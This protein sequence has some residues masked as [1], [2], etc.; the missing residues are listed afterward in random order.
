MTIYVYDPQ[1]LD[2]KNFIGNSTCKAYPYPNQI[3]EV[4][5]SGAVDHR[6]PYHGDNDIRFEPRNE[7]S[8]PNIFEMFDN[9]RF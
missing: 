2:C 4:I 1:C 8:Y 3:P 9:G 6:K 7:N 5:A